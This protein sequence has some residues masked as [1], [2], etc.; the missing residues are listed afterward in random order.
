MSGVTGSVVEDAALDWLEHS[1]WKVAH[2]P[3]IAA[4]TPGA[5]RTDS[6]VIVSARRLRDTHTR[7]QHTRRPGSPCPSWTA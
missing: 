1:G 2:E 6:R 4:Y 5:E 7:R 3:H